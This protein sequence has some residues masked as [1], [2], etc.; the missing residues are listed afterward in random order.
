M[1]LGAPGAFPNA[2]RARVLW[3]GLAAGEPP[4]VDLSRL[5]A[6]ALERRGFER[7]GRE[8][9]PHLTIGRVREAR[10]D[11]TPALAAAPPLAAQEAARFRVGALHVVKSTLSTGGSIYETLVEA[12]LRER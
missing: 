4:F 6:R 3:I 8:F 1:T 11:W 7:E 10:H 5:L 12:A 9:T 2:H